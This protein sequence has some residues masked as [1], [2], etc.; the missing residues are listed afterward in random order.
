MIEDSGREG[1]EGIDGG[2]KLPVIGY[3]DVDQT[4]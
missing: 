2:T 1:G 3:Y 4:V